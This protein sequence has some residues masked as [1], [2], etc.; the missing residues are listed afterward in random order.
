MD[1]G[2]VGGKNMPSTAGG[3]IR[4]RGIGPRHPSQTGRAIFLPPRG[5]TDGEDKSGGD[6]SMG[7]FGTEPDAED[8]LDPHSQTIAA[9]GGTP[10]SR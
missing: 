6:E 4:G 7:I 5:G 3:E 10:I 2:G 1:S 9:G 8:E